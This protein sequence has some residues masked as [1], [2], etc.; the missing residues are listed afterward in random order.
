MAL[1]DSELQRIRYELG[2][3]NLDTA[4]EPYIGIAAFFSQVL[5]PYLLDGAATTST[6]TVV[7]AGT[8]TP[9]SIVLASA[10]G[11]TVGDVLVIDADARQERATLQ[12]LSGTT[13]TMQL[14]LAHGPGTY[15]VVVEG[16]E[17]IIRDILRELRLLSSGMNGTASALSSFRSRVGLKKVDDVEFFGGGQT[18]A[19]QGIDPLTQLNQLREFWR[20]ELASA[21]GIQRLNGRN[22]SGGS[23]VSVY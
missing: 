12:S 6:S 15:S 9:T 21:I 4:A 22:N 1:T 14:S 20:D 18:L 19:S 3:P 5:Q 23:S 2:Y 8:P 11:I 7:E 13:A 17:Q 16:A 10:A